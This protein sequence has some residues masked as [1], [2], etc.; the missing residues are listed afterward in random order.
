M[1]TIWKGSQRLQG[2]TKTLS[3]ITLALLAFIV[4]CSLLH[5]DHL[6]ENPTDW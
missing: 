2:L 1:K 4:G 6:I 3:L 5:K